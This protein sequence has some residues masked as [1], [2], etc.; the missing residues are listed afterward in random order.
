MALS[1]IDKSHV[2]N[3][4]LS[5]NS[6]TNHNHNMLEV[7]KSNHADY[8]QLKLIAKQINMLRQEALEII[9]N[10]NEQNELHR[11]KTSFKLV[12]GNY[13]FLYEKTE[14]KE[15]YFSLISPEEWDKSKANFQDKFLGKYFY[16]FDKKFVY[17]QC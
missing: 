13:Y 12:S 11:I 10:S 3:L 6:N 15:R 8:S 16:D 4:L 5:L 2:E 1:N 7:V 14:L 9:N 17:Q